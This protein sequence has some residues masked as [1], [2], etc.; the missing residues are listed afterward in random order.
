MLK[1][2]FFKNFL[3][4]VFFVTKNFVKSNVNVRLNFIGKCCVTLQKNFKGS[5]KG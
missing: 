4:P 2:S 3:R 1:Y 5:L